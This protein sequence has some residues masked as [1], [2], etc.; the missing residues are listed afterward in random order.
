MEKIY[1]VSSATSSVVYGN[2]SCAI[3]EH[4][5]SKFP[6]GYFTDVNM[7][8]EVA[9][10][11][12][13]RKL[14][15]TNS[16]REFEKR[17]KPWMNIRP[18]LTPTSPDTFLN[19]IPLT[20]NWDNIQYGVD[21]RYLFDIFKDGENGYSLKYKI[22]RDKLEFDVGITVST[23]LQQI[24]LFK[25]LY[26]QISWDRPYSHRIAS[27]AMIPRSIIKHISNLINL[28]VVIQ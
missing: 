9:F 19:D 24:D 23:V 27:E 16:K 20:K 18:I 22:N 1:A 8:T 2:I 5:L 3:R 13:Y 17:K 26:N 12:I 28:F 21:K 25:Y 14:G 6:Y 7:S 4:I 15:G 10:R 11:N